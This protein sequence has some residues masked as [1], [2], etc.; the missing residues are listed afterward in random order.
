MKFVFF[1]FHLHLLLLLSC[2]LNSESLNT[3]TESS[4]NSE[5]VDSVPALNEMPI[6]YNI[7]CS[8]ETAF[9]SDAVIFNSGL[10]P[11][12]SIECIWDFGDGELIEGTEVEYLFELPGRQFV[13]LSILSNGGVVITDSIAVVLLPERLLE[14]QEEI[15]SYRLAYF[16]ETQV[17]YWIET[18]EYGRIYS[19][20][21]E[22]WPTA[23][24]IKI[25]IL[26]ATYLEFGNTWNDVPTQLQQILNYEV[27]Y[28]VPLEMLSAADRDIVRRNLQDMTYQQ[29]AI[30]MMGV[31][32]GQIG[33]S[34]YN[35]ASNVLIFLLGGASGGC[36]DK[37][38]S[39]SPNFSSVHVGRY[40]LESRTIENDNRNSM[41]AM[42]I[43]CRMIFNNDV[44]GTDSVGCIVLRDCFQYF[45]LQGYDNYEKHG[46]LSV[47]PSVN[48]WIGWIEKENEFLFYGLNVLYSD[49][50][51]LEDR[52]ADHYRE[53]LRNMLIEL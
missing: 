36:T 20:Q 53:I 22:V 4:V 29:L 38:H 34:S 51:S 10:L 3:G 8:A 46:H 26:M 11:D 23:S 52:G 44:P 9:V 32:Q 47:A 14:V 12:S 7:S 43:A 39:I 1:T 21:N 16:P 40:M 30:S 35:A 19:N 48:L 41:R 27:G 28:T 24:A 42:A 33:N 18:S 15:E 37:I 50:V 49:G 17:S 5:V 13:S 6:A 25:F 2:G 45:S 31:N